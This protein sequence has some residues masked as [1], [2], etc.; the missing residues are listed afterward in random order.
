MCRGVTAEGQDLDPP[1]YSEL[2]GVGRAGTR[3][4]GWSW[5]QAAWKFKMR[6]REGLVRCLQDGLPDRVA[7]WA[8]GL[9][10]FW[11]HQHHLP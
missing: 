2:A 3:I 11:L 6:A 1:P 10:R 8:G 7:S 5:G 9:L 4:A